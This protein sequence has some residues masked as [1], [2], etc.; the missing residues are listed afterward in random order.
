MFTDKGQQLNNV[1]FELQGDPITSDSA[2]VISN[3]QS[4]ADHLVMPYLAANAVHSINDST[5]SE[6]AKQAALNKIVL[7][8]INF[9]S[10][11]RVWNVPS[12]RVLLNMA[13]C[14]ENWELDS[15]LSELIFSRFLRTKVPEWI[16][17]FPEVNIWT[18]EAAILQ[19]AQSEKFYLPVLKNVLYPRF[20]SF[21]NVISVLNNKEN[22]KFVKLYDL[23]ILYKRE[24]K[25]P[26]SLGGA[27]I[28]ALTPRP[29]EEPVPTYFQPT[30]LDIMFSE[31]PITVQVI[32]KSK[33]LNRVPLK[34]NKTEKWLENL[35]LEKDKNV[36]QVLSSIPKQEESTGHG[37]TPVPLS[38][39]KKIPVLGP[40]I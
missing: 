40:I 26:R 4:L 2:V 15:T 19:K 5:V 12:I 18:E 16:V 21:Y 9:F 17:L 14:D 36:S 31:Y 29:P 3:H 34:R 24:P 6:D 22:Y 1:N 35:W 28:N 32:I 33:F 11:F 23:T 13:K 10:W 7:P 25:K 37:L 27:I 38:P 20:S 30:L 8:R 39:I